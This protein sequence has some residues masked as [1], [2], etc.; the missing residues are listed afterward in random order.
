MLPPLCRRG[1]FLLICMA[2]MTAM[3]AVAYAY[4]LSMRVATDA[5]P[6]LTTYHLVHQTARAGITH[7]SELLIRDYLD[8]PRVPTSEVGPHRIFFDPIDN[9]TGNNFLRDSRAQGYDATGSN[10]VSPTLW[11]DNDLL[12]PAK[13]LNPY[14]AW[15]GNE[16]RQ[17][18]YAYDTT[19]FS[20]FTSPAVPRYVESMYWSTDYL[21]ET[22]P[23]KTDVTV[24][25]G[26]APEINSPI[27]YDARWQPVADRSKAR[28]RLRYTVMCEDLSGHL[29]GGLPAAF[30]RSNTT[31]GKGGPLAVD[32]DLVADGLNN[33]GTEADTAWALKYAPTACSMLPIAAPTNH[34]GIW[35]NGPGGLIFSLG[36]LGMGGILPN[37]SSW[38]ASTI[39]NGF[40]ATSVVNSLG[41]TLPAGILVCSPWAW[42]SSWEYV[43]LS[44]TGVPLVPPAPGT[45]L[46]LNRTI[47]HRAYTWQGQRGSVGGSP[48]TD[49]SFINGGLVT[50]YGAPT[51]WDAN[52]DPEASDTVLDGYAYNQGPTDCPWRLNPLTAPALAIQALCSGFRASQTWEHSYAYKFTVPWDQWVPGSPPTP[53]WQIPTTPAGWQALMTPVSGSDKTASNLRIPNPFRHT[54]ESRRRGTGI[55]VHPFAQ[56]VISPSAD[57]PRSQTDPYY[58][59]PIYGTTGDNLGRFCDLYRGYE[60]FFASSKARCVGTGWAHPDSSVRATM[61]GGFN[62]LPRD[63]DGNSIYHSSDADY[64]PPSSPTPGDPFVVYVG[65]NPFYTTGAPPVLNQT[66]WDQI[67]TPLVGVNSIWLDALTAVSATANVAAAAYQ[68]NVSYPCAPPA[69]GDSALFGGKW[70]QPT[71]DSDTGSD[72]FKH[73]AG[74]MTN[75]GDMDRIFLTLLGEDPDHPGNNLSTREAVYPVVKGTGTSYNATPFKPILSMLP[76]YDPATTDYD[77]TFET[78]QPAQAGPPPIPARAAWTPQCPYINNDNSRLIN[79][80]RS[81]LL[82]IRR[83]LY[84]NDTKHPAD[85]T[86]FTN[87]A[88]TLVRGTPAYPDLKTTQKAKQL[89]RCRL[90][91]AERIINDMR[92]SFFGANLRYKDRTRTGHASAGKFRPYDL[93][94]DGWAICSAYC[95]SDLA[96]LQV[97]M[98]SGTGTYTSY[99]YTEPADW[100]KVVFDDQPDNPGRINST[101][102][103]TAT[104][105][106]VWV[107]FKDVDTT[108]V[109]NLTND[110]TTSDFLDFLTYTN[111]DGSFPA[112]SP[113][114]SPGRA[115]YTRWFYPAVRVLAAADAVDGAVNDGVAAYPPDTYFSLSGYFTLEKSHFYRMISRG[116][117][118][119]ELKKS[120]VDFAILDCAFQLDPDG[121]MLTKP[122]VIDVGTGK[123]R[124]ATGLED[125]GIIYQRWLKDLY[126]GS[127]DR[128]GFSR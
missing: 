93:D 96:A 68:Q 110:S 51:R 59:S 81:S 30:D 117:V 63:A 121:N 41:V 97:V 114:G 39:Q 109:P 125:S 80:R 74:S 46:G 116:E 56:F 88:S 87:E 37:A 94:G 14:R 45:R 108:A 7:A 50:P 82:N 55:V 102:L 76:V 29:L 43:S 90:R 42:R 47:P 118:W 111:D 103:I 18:D 58:P 73:S 120:I 25:P 69:G 33:R 44:K 85:S 113:T 112:G 91:D 86:H 9:Y 127:K 115:G 60:Q 72:G 105:G 8:R 26:T 123:V 12:P 32:G 98:D 54:F 78:A 31:T 124:D 71:L 89:M 122:N 61:L 6:A 27:Y 22:G 79:L 21:R 65:S 70:G 35:G 5:G 92:M 128:T 99:R 11:N 17:Y 83:N 34:R 106:P 75:V 3:G 36:W 100:T 119:D 23:G 1:S 126:G 77:P 19:W 28:Y 64:H 24:V 49:T 84:L 57:N 20:S 67:S 40:T 15:R 107:C 10:T 16:G 62:I 48:R 13:L 53:K 2:L 38:G 4:V 95:P 52:P 101:S 104:S 66:A